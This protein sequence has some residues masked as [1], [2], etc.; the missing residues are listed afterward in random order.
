[1][2]AVSGW[3]GQLTNIAAEDENSLDSSNILKGD[4]LR[5]AKPQTQN[6]YNEGADED[7]LPRE[8]ADGSVGVSGTRRVT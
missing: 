1:M 3:D 4:R 2:I 7:D 8:V 6:R 5:H